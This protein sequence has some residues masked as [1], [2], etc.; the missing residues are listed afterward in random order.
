MYIS[1]VYLQIGL[2]KRKKK[3]DEKDIEYEVVLNVMTWASEEN[4]E[5]NTI[6]AFQTSDSNTYWY[7]IFD[8]QLMHIPY[9][10]N[11]HVMHSILQL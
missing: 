6:G 8:G 4:I 10:N 3:P 11:I 1:I 5:Y 9:I 7:S 2:D